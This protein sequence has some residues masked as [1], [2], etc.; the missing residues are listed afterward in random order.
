MTADTAAPVPGR[1]HYV[2]TR[3]L[4][5]AQSAVFALLADPAR[6]H[7]TEPTDWVRGPLE[8]EPAPLTE[9]D[10]IFGIEMFHENAGGRYVVH[11]RVVALEPDRT[12]A[13][14][15]GQYGSDGSWGGGGWICRY[16]LATVGESTRVTLTYDWSAVPEP[17]RAEF[18]LP[19]FP[20]SFLEESLASLEEAVTAGGSDSPAEA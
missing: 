1:D 7:E 6:H 19:P 14:E 3:T 2:V 13:W 8:T 17:L 10:Q 9:V 16:D 5:A 12:I 4:D 18:G 11:N 15:P 20:P